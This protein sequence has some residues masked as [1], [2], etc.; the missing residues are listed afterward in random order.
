MESRD[1]LIIKTYDSLEFESII[2]IDKDNKD[3]AWI[4]VEYRNA[5]S[6]A[7]SRPSKATFKKCNDDVFM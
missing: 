4:Q 6:D 3:N 2:L 7:N 1:W 5:N